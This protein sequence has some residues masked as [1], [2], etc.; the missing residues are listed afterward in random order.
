M[1]RKNDELLLKDYTDV[2][3]VGLVVDKDLLQ[4]IVFIR[5]NSVTWKSKK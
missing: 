3:Y 5:G 2:G 1:F 4:V